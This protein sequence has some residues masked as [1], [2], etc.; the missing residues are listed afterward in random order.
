MASLSLR[1]WWK[2]L[3]S[4]AGNRRRRS[5][6]VELCAAQSL[7]HRQFLSG[8]VTTLTPTTTTSTSGTSALVSG[9][10]S[11]IT[12]GATSSGGTTSSGTTS[13]TSSSGTSSSGTST[14]S[15]PSWLAPLLD[16]QATLKTAADRYQ[17][18]T[19]DNRSLLSSRLAE[20][21]A[22]YEA[23]EDLRAKQSETL[24]DEV[25]ERLDVSEEELSDN[26]R[27]LDDHS[28][29]TLSSLLLVRDRTVSAVQ[30]HTTETAQ[31][32]A[33]YQAAVLKI[34][35]THSLLL[36]RADDDFQ[37]AVDQATADREAALTAAGD[38]H[39]NALAAAA[40]RFDSAMD[41]ADAAFDTA[42]DSAVG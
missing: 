13:G 34:Q 27:D 23:G 26:L 2:Q 9:G 32:D 19:T 21:L 7:E 15:A 36:K 33:D 17:Q 38:R 12:G 3:A 10:L 39:E 22:T 14:K 37:S 6:A 20:V 1:D 29:R 5:R 40:A 35:E 41:A 25:R 24:L 30:R 31:S 11:T 4:R 42:V 8:L 16:W 18:N 28:N